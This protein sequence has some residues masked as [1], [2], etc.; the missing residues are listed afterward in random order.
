MSKCETCGYLGRTGPDK[1]CDQILYTGHKRPCPYGDPNCPAYI[2]KAAFRAQLAAT[3]HRANKA[4]QIVIYHETP[5]K[6]EHMKTQEIQP[7]AK[8]DREKAM[9]LYSQ[10]LTDHQIAETLGAGYTTAARWRKEAGLTPNSGDGSV[11]V[12]GKTMDETEAQLPALLPA[13]ML[14]GALSELLAKLPPDTRVSIENMT[15][16]VSGVII[17]RQ[18]SADGSEIVT[19]ELTLG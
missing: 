7:R 16:D 15:V 13:S 6:D 8:F 2:T 12:L 4:P 19:A 18:I 5:R 1:T 17:R 14:A 9:E 3:G 10:G 11:R